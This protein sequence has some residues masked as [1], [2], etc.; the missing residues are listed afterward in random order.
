MLLSIFA[1]AGL[2]LVLYLTGFFVVFTPLP[3]ILTAFKKGKTSALISAVLVLVGLWAL[4]RFPEKPWEFLPMMVFYPHLELKAVALLSLIYCAYYLWT[5]VL[6]V[7]AS[8][9][10][11]RYARVEPLFG[12]MTAA[13]IGLPLAVLWIGAHAFGFHLLDGISESMNFLLK[14]MVDLQE[15]SGMSS[16]DVAYLREFA[17]AL[18]ARMI[19]ILPSLWINFSM[20]ALSLNILF[21]RRWTP[22]A[23]PFPEWAEFSLWRLGESWIWLPIG[24]GAAFFLNHYFVQSDLLGLVLINALI[25][26]G[27]LYFLQ[28]LAVV[29]FFFRRRLTSWMRLLAY[30]V[31]LLFIQ[32]AGVV[33]IAVGLFDF[34]FDFRKLK[35]LT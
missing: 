34:W 20:L 33:V 14:K 31:I 19:A 2:S 6:V 29:S 8:R 11:G 18:V 23:H 15:S 4:Y 9:R 3:V 22:A 30:L 12:G 28:G 13:S 26:L 32:F 21:L 1:T 10:T 17:P 16:E 24:A 27:G 25:V 5:A 35:K 7:W